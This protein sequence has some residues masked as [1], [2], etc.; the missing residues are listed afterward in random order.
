MTRVKT[1]GI[2]G[3]I[4]P[5][6]TVAYY[7]NILE[8]CRGAYPPVIINS[9]DLTK[10]IGLITDARFDDL[11]VYLG[12]E[13]E[14]LAR[15]GAEIALFASNTPHIIFDTLRERSPLPLISIVET[16]RDAAVR[17]GLRRVALFGTRFTMRA[18]FYARTFAEAGISVVVP[19]DDDLEHIH[20][21]YMSELVNA[22]FLDSTRAEL[23]HVIDRIPNIDGVILGGTELPLLL[24]ASEHAGVQLL[25]TGRLHAERAVEAM[26]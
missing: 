22:Q 25:D 24:S 23:L 21:R 3:G 17:A 6:S 5:E 18:P 2:I 19:N 10:M 9:I 16:A 7:R 12:A 20:H 15:A 26:Q 13:L 1:L 11:A 8:L 4:A 14:K